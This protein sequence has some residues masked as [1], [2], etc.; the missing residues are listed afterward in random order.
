MKTKSRKFN[1]NGLV[2][3]TDGKYTGEEPSQ[4]LEVDT[5]EKFDRKFSVA[6]NFYNYYLDRDD[7]IPIIHEYMQTHGYNTKDCKLIQKTNIAF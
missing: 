7:Y 6:L 2:S 3:A 4:W 5:K 1:K